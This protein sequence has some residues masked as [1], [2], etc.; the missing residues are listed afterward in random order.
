MDK[1]S[2]THGA[3]SWAELLTRD[4]EGSKRFYRDLIGW[5]MIE[6]PMAGGTYIVLKAGGEAMAGMMAMP[7]SVPAR[8]PTHWETYITVQDVDAVAARAGELG[9]SLLV[10]P[11]DV[12]GVGRFSCIQDPQGGVMN[13]IQYLK[14]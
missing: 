1:R 3:L 2:E 4:L 8:V 7:G 12:P 10:P 14:K 11:T 5:E 6:M 13:V 9:A